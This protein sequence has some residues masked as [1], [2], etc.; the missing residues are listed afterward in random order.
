LLVFQDSMDAVREYSI[1]LSLGDG[2]TQLLGAKLVDDFE[3]LPIA[4]PPISLNWDQGAECTAVRQLGLVVTDCASLL[5]TYFST[6]NKN[7]SNLVERGV[8]TS[9][10][11]FT[12]QGPEAPTVV[13]QQDSLA[14]ALSNLIFEKILSIS[15]STVRTHMLRVPDTLKNFLVCDVNTVMFCSEF[16]YSLF[17]GA[18]VVAVLTFVVAVIL[19]TI[20][21]PYVWT[22]TGA[23]YIPLVF[24]YSFGVSPLCFPMIPS[25]L[26]NEILEFLNMV[27]PDKLSWPQS[28]QKIPN[29]AEDASISAS[30]CIVTC[31]QVPFVYLDWTE[32]LAWVFCDVAIDACIATE[33]WLSA[34]AWV[35][36]I[37]TLK[38]LS[39]ALDRSAIVLQGTD[40]D[41]KT[42][43]RLCAALTSWKTV[44]ILLLCGLG[45]YALPMLLL[46]PFQ[47]FIS[48]LQLGVSTVTMSHLRWGE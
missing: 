26:G 33:K 7:A 43:F 36:G 17:S 35:Q 18:V 9:F 28:L 16:R 23:L 42:A 44:P 10:P 14:A 38:S 34:S 46:V 11:S 15:P 12:V 22:I 32:P 31:E 3:K 8:L 41:M 4:F 30:E 5:L 27:I 19:R 40:D 48:L 6:L 37:S 29:C 47:L 25:C 39:E 20:G 13:V 1:Q 24:F 21:I 2:A 45:V